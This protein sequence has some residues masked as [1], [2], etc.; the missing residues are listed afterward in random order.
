MELLPECPVLLMHH[1]CREV[2]VVCK[3]LYY[4]DETLCKMFGNYGLEL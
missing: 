4:N 1:A 2:H 3:A